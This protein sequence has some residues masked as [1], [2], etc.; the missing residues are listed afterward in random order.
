[1]KYRSSSIKDINQSIIIRVIALDR[2]KKNGFQ[3]IS[4]G[5]IALLDSYFIQR[6]I[7]I[8]YMSKSIEEKIHRLL[9]QLW[10]L[11]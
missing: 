10:P 11:T 2:R 4:F 1:M 5:Y 7:I 8:K 6:Y 3:A 9:S